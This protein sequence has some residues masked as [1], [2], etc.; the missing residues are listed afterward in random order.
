MGAGT[1]LGVAA[2][3]AIVAVVVFKVKI[4]G[5][6]GFSG[7][8]RGDEAGILAEAWLT[9]VPEANVIKRN[10]VV[11]HQGKPPLMLQREWENNLL[12]FTGRD[13]FYYVEILVGLPGDT[14]ELVELVMSFVVDLD[15]PESQEVVMIRIGSIKD[16]FGI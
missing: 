9:N 10:R 14:G 8:P 7:D 12:S 5:I 6:P 15:G 13:E 2:A 16:V 4:P 11:Q 3:A 1:V